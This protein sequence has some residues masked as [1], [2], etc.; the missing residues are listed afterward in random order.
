MTDPSA[1]ADALITA[2]RDRTPIAPFTSVN[3]FLDADT[4]YKAQA[5]VERLN[6]VLPPGFPV[7]PLTELPGL[8]VPLG[9]PPVPPGLS[10]PAGGRL[11]RF[12]PASAPRTTAG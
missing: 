5:L 12:A 6:P 10:S 9:K 8:V 1:I 2:Q 7:A 11:L 4:G 3:P